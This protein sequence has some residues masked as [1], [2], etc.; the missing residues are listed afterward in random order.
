MPRGCP[1]VPDQLP[2]APEWSQ[3]R[4][5]V[6]RWCEDTQSELTAELA[7]YQEDTAAWQVTSAALEFC[8]EVPAI[9]TTSDAWSSAWLSVVEATGRP[10]LFGGQKQWMRSFGRN[11]IKD[12]VVLSLQTGRLMPL[13]LPFKLPRT[14]A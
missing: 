13:K 4:D 3:L 2:T 1:W 8:S 14:W 5:E 7:K 9:L 10:R 12:P 11:R 6:L